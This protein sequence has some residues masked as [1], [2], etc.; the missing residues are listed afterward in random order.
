MNSLRERKSLTSQD[1][2]IAWIPNEVALSGSVLVWEYSAIP[3]RLE[4]AA[5]C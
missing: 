5:E 3:G 4:M 1:V 2:P